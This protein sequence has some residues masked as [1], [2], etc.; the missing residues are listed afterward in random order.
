MANSELMKRYLSDMG[1][2]EDEL[3][4]LKGK[5]EYVTKERNEQNKIMSENNLQL[6]IECEIILNCLTTKRKQ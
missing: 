5:L 3:K 6:S 2:E 1:I 4:E